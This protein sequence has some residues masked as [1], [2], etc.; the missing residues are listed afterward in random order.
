MKAFLVETEDKDGNK[1]ELEVKKPSPKMIQEGQIVY[2]ATWNKAANS[3]VCLED[4]LEDILRKKGVWNDEKEQERKRLE[5]SLLEGEK[6][7]KQGGGR[8]KGSHDAAKETAIRM[9]K[10][11][12][13]LQNLLTHRNK[14]KQHTAEAIADQARFNY[15]VANC[16]VLAKDGSP[17]FKNLDDYVSKMEDKSAN[18]AATKLMNVIY[19]LEENW[20][21][22][23][24]EVAFLK[25]W[26]FMNAAGQLLNDEGKTV[27]ESGRLVNTEGYVV[28]DA[29]NMV[30]LLGNVI[31]AS[32]EYVVEFTPF[33]GEQG[34][35][36]TDP[37][38]LTDTDFKDSKDSGEPAVKDKSVVLDAV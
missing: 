1:L 13:E 19:D 10:Y 29:G 23:L 15:L 21:D 6:R 18:D 36:Y 4:Q 7:L 37:S 2:A 20:Q 32:G 16:T 12:R 8:L 25:K 5:K 22:K 38:Q 35:T 30:D 24:P 9:L 31:D 34:E 11:R 26:K 33:E 14:H 28:N 27:D 17:Y 3:D